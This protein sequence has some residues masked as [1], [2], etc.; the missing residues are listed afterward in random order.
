MLNKSGLWLIGFVMALSALQGCGPQA[1]SDANQTGSEVAE[2]TKNAGKS[3]SAGAASAEASLSN[4]A[5]KAKKDLANDETSLKVKQA[6]S[7]AT[8]VDATNI[9]V[10]SSGKTVTIHGSVPTTGQKV[11]AG[12]ITKDILGSTYKITNEL[13]VGP[14]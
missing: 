12:T 8:D 14:G 2:T 5:A 13:M 3:I 6:L 9:K 11:K 10:D 4:D 1:K 7:S